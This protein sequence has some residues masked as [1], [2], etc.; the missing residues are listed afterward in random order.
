MV[1][2][3]KHMPQRF[4]VIIE[5]NPT[6][7]LNLRGRNDQLVKQR[8]QRKCR[9]NNCLG[10]KFFNRKVAEAQNF[11]KNFFVHLLRLCAAAMNT[12]HPTPHSHL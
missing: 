10:F 5:R 1:F 3:A 7:D 8:P 12:P 2:H 9:Y 4:V 11:F 6:Y